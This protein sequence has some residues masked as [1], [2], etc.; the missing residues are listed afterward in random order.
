MHHKLLMI[1]NQLGESIMG[2]YEC[3]NCDETFHL[4]E[5][6]YDGHEICDECRE[7]TE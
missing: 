2:D 3:V 5:P 1:N 4:D 7:E 6:P